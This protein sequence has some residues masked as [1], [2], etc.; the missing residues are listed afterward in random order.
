ME[1]KD[2]VFIYHWYEYVYRAK[3]ELLAF[4]LNRFNETVCLRIDNFLPFCY[5]EFR[6]DEKYLN[7]LTNKIKLKNYINNIIHNSNKKNKSTQY[8]INIIKKKKLYY[9]QLVYDE[10][11]DKYNEQLFTYV[12]V[13]GNNRFFCYTIRQLFN[14]VDHKNF[15]DIKDVD[16]IHSVVHEYNVNPII[17]YTTQK[18]ITCCGWVDV[19][20]LLVSDN[21]DGDDGGKITRLKKEYR[22][23]KIRDGSEQY[24]HKF[25]IYPS[26]MAFDLEVY[27]A[28]GT[29]PD[30]SKETDRIFQI[31]I[32]FLFKNKE[33][34]SEEN[35]LLTLGDPQERQQSQYKVIT[36]NNEFE[37]IK[38][39][40][41]IIDEKQPNIIM[42]Y[43]IFKF[44]IQ[45][46][47]GRYCFYKKGN[48]N[49]N[50]NDFEYR[51][52]M[53]DPNKCKLRTQKILWSSVAFNQQE[54]YYLDI[55]G[56]LFMDL[57]PIIE[58]DYKLD[59]YKLKTVTQ[60]FLEDTKDDLDVHGIFSAYQEGVLHKVKQSE[61][62]A[63]CGAYCIKDS[64]LCLQLFEKLTMWYSLTSLA[65]VCHIPMITLYTQGQQIKVFAQVYQLCHRDN[66][67][68]Q[69]DGYK[70]SEN[71]NYE[72]AMVF[73]PKPGIYKN[74][75]PFDFS[76]LYPTTII[77][78]NICYT[79]MIDEE[80]ENAKHI[81][82]Y[83]CHVVEWDEKGST[84]GKN[85]ALTVDGTTTG[86]KSNNGNII[87]NGNN[88]NGHGN[89]GVTTTK[90]HRYRF[91]FLKKPKG[92]VPR[93]LEQLLQKRSDTKKKLKQTR[94]EDNQANAFTIMLLDHRQL[95]LKV[96]ANC[97][98][99]VMGTTKGSIPFLS[100]A[101]CTTALGRQNILKASL[102]LQNHYGAQVIYGDTDSCYITFQQETSNQI[103]GTVQ[104]LWNDC[105]R[106]E[107][108]IIDL[109][110]KPMKLAFE[111]VIYDKFLILTKKRYVASKIDQ[112]GKYLG[113]TKR[114]ILLN[115]RDT[116]PII[117]TLYENIVWRLFDHD[118]RKP[119]SLGKIDISNYINDF[120]QKIFVYDDEVKDI[121]NFIISKRVGS[122]ESYKYKNLGNDEK[123]RQ[124]RLTQM[125]I[126]M[127]CICSLEI[128][129]DGLKC[130]VFCPACLHYFHYQFPSHIQLAEKIKYRGGI[131][132][133]GERLSYVFTHHLYP[134][135]KIY[136]KIETPSY[137]ME[138]AEHLRLDFLYYTKLMINPIDECLSLIFPGS[139][140][141]FTEH[142]YR[143]QKFLVTQELKKYFCRKIS[144]AT[145]LTK[146]IDQQRIN[147]IPQHILKE[148]YNSKPTT[149]S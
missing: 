55:P 7:D 6:V 50:I 119:I 112:N 43:N 96:S 74:V 2:N 59:N 9:N 49:S 62:L 149:T 1:I 145:K 15:L 98:Y 40:F 73:E 11:N 68:I 103:H 100:G 90:N 48:V 92:I 67:I 128:C 41:K 8:E 28:Q 56:I 16:S 146:H 71:Y 141:M 69:S 63:V 26:L 29:F 133:P 135:D 136:R 129:V 24:N 46:I 72:G 114:G 35:I 34:K 80:N 123:V 83:L 87:D 32:C 101:M 124:K 107:N 126:F 53:L 125:G 113:L 66:I 27:S 138:N 130:N 144:P 37:I 81:P 147:V 25:I 36:L 10:K 143:Y 22:V 97:V 137:V 122:R 60:Y 118:N 61:K 70:H 82:D 47:L 39:F 134:N 44:D 23:V 30:A 64:L 99:G 42:G 33:E 115:R 45:Y 57:L 109:F 4:C 65:H 38:K 21:G 78:Y 88:N 84:V 93:L 31:S 120:I 104:Q 91:R 75:I 54:F 19:E 17:Q 102:F 131:V 94:Q 76:S 140:I 132:Y 142:F 108:E 18:G 148:I 58:R 51:I 105:L 12:Q 110:P 86:S 111:E 14:N 127:K 13:L 20:G 89:D 116:A 85:D 77:A 3:W 52:G 121:N 5:I 117:Q 95:A 106:I 79:T 139:K